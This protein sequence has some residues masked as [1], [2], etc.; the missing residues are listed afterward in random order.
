MPQGEE[1]DMLRKV[2]R[3]AYEDTKRLIWI[4]DPVSLR[5]AGGR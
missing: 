2:L 1:T 4:A 3:R 5:S